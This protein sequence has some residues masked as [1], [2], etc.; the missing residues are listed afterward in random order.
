[1]SVYFEVRIPA[2]IIVAQRQNSVQLWCKLSRAV[3]KSSKM[4]A[5]ARVSIFGHSFV[6]RLGDY[7]NQEHFWHNLNLSPEEFVLKFSGLGGS[8][9]HTIQRKLSDISEFDAEIVF[10]QIGSNDLSIDSCCPEKLARDIVSLAEF[11]TLGENVIIVV[12]GQ[13][14]RRGYPA[15]HRC[16]NFW[17]KMQISIELYNDKVVKTNVALANLLK[18]KPTMKF[19]RHRG[20]WSCKE[21]M[22]CDDGVHLNQRGMYKYAYSIRNALVHAKN[23]V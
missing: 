2:L 18:D 12:I 10:V 8:T 4:A 14:L 22:L 19:W 13:I 20:F 23:S 7:T 5:P 11:I 15:E 9:V 21:N 6:R 3:T 16:R 17:K 1:M